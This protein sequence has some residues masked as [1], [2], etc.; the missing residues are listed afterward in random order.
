MFTAL[1]NTL[2]SDDPIQ[3]VRLKIW[4]AGALSCLLLG[5]VQVVEVWL[6]AV[7]R[8]AS[9]RLI[10]A[11]AITSVLFYAL[12]RTRLDLRL[13]RDPGLALPQLVI[14]CGFALWS[15]AITGPARGAILLIL[16]G[17]LMYGMFALASR[18]SR[19]LAVAA[20]A[21]LAGVMTWRALTDP[22]GYPWRLEVVHFVVAAIVVGTTASLSMQFGALRNR[23]GRQDRDLK[24]ALEQLERLATRDALTQTH[25]RRHMTELMAMQARQHERSGAP[26]C[27]ARLDIDL[28]KGINDRHGH[29]AGDMV[30]Q[31]FAGIAQEV[32]RTS[33]L[34]CRWGGEEFLVLFPDTPSDLAH[35]ALQRLHERLAREE[36]EVLGA[37]RRVSVSAGLTA[38]VVGE[39]MELATER[40]DKAM[41]SAKAGGRSRTVL[42]SCAAGPAREPVGIALAVAHPALAQHWQ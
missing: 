2:L 22:A 14:G 1:R 4:A 12:L 21:A 38:C 39:A 20:L 18:Q 17:L 11:M 29:A 5:I 24:R 10:A 23:L 9:D 19:G 15:Y 41:R 7:D 25:N 3:Q 35:V 16:A 32:L 42:V 31:R 27:V 6:A 8:A 13:G 26:M 33:D 40:A 28:F 30:L 36:I 37:G 34:L